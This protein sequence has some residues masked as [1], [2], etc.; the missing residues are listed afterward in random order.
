[1]DNLLALSDLQRMA[2]AHNYTFHRK[3]NTNTMT[4]AIMIVYNLQYALCKDEQSMILIHVFRRVMFPKSEK[5]TRPRNRLFVLWH[6]CL[7]VEMLHPTLNKAFLGHHDRRETRWL[8]HLVLQFI[9]IMGTIVAVPE[10]R[11]KIMI[12]ITDALNWC[13]PTSIY[14]SPFVVFIHIPRL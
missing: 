5:F 8:D 3:T 13:H 10:G 12:I 4:T 1:M 2:I 7:T 14:S 6:P 9:I 11:M